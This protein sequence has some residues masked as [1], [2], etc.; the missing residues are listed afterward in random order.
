MSLLNYCRL[1]RPLNVIIAF[2]SVLIAAALSV[3]FSFTLRVLLAALSA[4]LIT[5]AANVIN[6]IFD[7]EIDKI[8]RPRRILA[9]GKLSPKA[10]MLFYHLL[11]LAGLAL[12]YVGGLYLFL[13][14][15]PVHILLYFYSARFKGTILA[16]NFVVS[17]VTATAFLY[18]ALAVNDIAAGIFPALFAFFFHFGREIIKDMQDISGDV[19]GGALTFAGKFGKKNATVLVNIL[20][21]FLTFLLFVPYVQGVYSIYYLW[22][23]LPGVALVLLGVC[24]L[25]WFKNDSLW[26]GRM[27]SLL[28]VDMFIGLIAIYVGNHYDLFINY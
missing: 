7:I 17:L 24:L 22:I 1:V 8:N 2:L 11:G 3:N 26:L 25:M 12:A 10:A 13:I 20:F 14:A 18:G 4:S 9:S 28:K 23:V 15:L 6:D 16:G 5:A 27:S 21:L 19:Q